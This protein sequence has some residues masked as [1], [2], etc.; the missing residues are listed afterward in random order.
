MGSREG[1][2]KQIEIYRAM[3]G[4]ERLNIAFQ[5]WEMSLE[6]MKSQEKL[7]NPGLSEQDIERK[8]R[9]RTRSGT[10]GRLEKGSGEN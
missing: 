1:A 8:V 4:Q 5:L 2:K 6:L 9:L 10:T 7:R 3:T